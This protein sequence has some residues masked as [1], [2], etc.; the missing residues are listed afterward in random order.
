MAESGHSPRP[1]FDLVIISAGSYVDVPGVR[2][3]AQTQVC[4]CV[5][6]CESPLMRLVVLS[7]T[8]HTNLFCVNFVRIG[9]RG[10]MDLYQLCI[11]R[12]TCNRK[13]HRAD[14]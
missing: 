4:V 3:C 11:Q 9:D 5:C 6:V 10:C 8:I 13:T 14:S 1:S 7:T 2:N 12:Y